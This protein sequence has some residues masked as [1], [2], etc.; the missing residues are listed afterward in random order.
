MAMEGE[1]QLK[2]FQMSSW[3]G[4]FAAQ[5]QILLLPCSDQTPSVRW[6]GLFQ[7]GH[8]PVSQKIF[9]EPDLFPCTAQSSHIWG[10]LFIQQTGM[11]E[12][13]VVCLELHANNR[14]DKT[15]RSPCPWKECSLAGRKPRETMP[16]PASLEAAAQ[17]NLLAETT[18]VN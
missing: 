6:E 13:P 9:A 1:D 16:F 11:W 4:R 8:L 7:L 14:Q 18:K 17:E 5:T 3:M 12:A 2:E 10:F 15:E